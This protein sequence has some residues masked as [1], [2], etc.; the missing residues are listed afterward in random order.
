M[1]THSLE[2]LADPTRR[3]IVETLAERPRAVGEITE[4]V[5]IQQS[6]VSRHLRILGEAGFVNL[7][8]EG[9]RHIYE[10]RTEPFRDLDDWLG[11][12]RQMWEDRLDRFD[13]A[14]DKLDQLNDRLDNDNA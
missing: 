5:G 2:I 13:K 3:A 7:K 11:R 1:P 14:L 6:G 10:L 9:T 12:F 8:K 4:L